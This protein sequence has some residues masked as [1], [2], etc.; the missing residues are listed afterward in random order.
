ML[1]QLTGM[2]RIPVSCANPL[3]FLYL[4]ATLHRGDSTATTPYQYVRK[5]ALPKVGII[6]VTITN[7]F[8]QL[9]QK[10]IAAAV[11]RV[12]AAAVL[13]IPRPVILRRSRRIYFP[14]TKCR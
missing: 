13:V 1:A 12:D 6:N 4:S 8:C 10:N 5:K 14:L 11:L 9:Y 3:V 2:K 7:H